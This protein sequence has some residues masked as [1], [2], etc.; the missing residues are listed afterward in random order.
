MMSFSAFPLVADQPSTGN[1]SCRQVAWQSNIFAARN[2]RG[3]FL[4]HV[5]KQANLRL[6]CE[7]K[8][9]LQDIKK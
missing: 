5:K 3:Q 7:S 8:R 1:L 6:D 9:P 2:R 4:V